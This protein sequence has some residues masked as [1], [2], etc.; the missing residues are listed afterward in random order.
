MPR[1]VDVGAEQGVYLTG[2]WRMQL[3]TAGSSGKPPVGYFDFEVF[4]PRE[5]S[6]YGGGF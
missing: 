4:G 5:L 6:G 1:A 3:Q 2:P